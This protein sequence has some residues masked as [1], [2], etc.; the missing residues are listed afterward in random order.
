MK[1]S[2]KNWLEWG[3]FAFG[4]VVVGGTLCFLVYDA[5][6][7]NGDPPRL[8]VTFG[9]PQQHEEYYAVPLT[10]HN[11]GGRTAEQVLVQVTLTVNEKKKETAEVQISFVPRKS[12]RQGFVTFENDPR[13][14]ELSGRAIGY[15][16]P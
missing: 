1:K 16:Q 8:E 15:E 9:Q 2:E 10:I 14:G 7:N 11:R 5:I 3:V 13:A 6:Y 12:S 4:A